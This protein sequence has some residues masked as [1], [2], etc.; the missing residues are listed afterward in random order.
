ML[1]RAPLH[2]AL[3]PRRAPACGSV[4]P[5]L[6]ARPAA[7]AVRPALRR[8]GQ[9]AGGQGGP[10][11]RGIGA[12]LQSL[13]RGVKRLRS[14]AGF[15][16]IERGMKSFLQA[17]QIGKL[18]ASGKRLCQIKKIR[19][20]TRQQPD[21]WNVRCGKAVARHRVKGSLAHIEPEPWIIMARKSVRRARVRFSSTAII[22]LR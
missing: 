21:L 5:H 19:Q 12:Q 4:A 10:N 6:G 18:R 1:R 9:F 22:Q 13:H 14:D 3:W 17:S 16:G 11:A 2:R 8:R 7:P 15:G 20:M